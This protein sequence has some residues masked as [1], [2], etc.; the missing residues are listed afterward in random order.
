M[1]GIQETPARLFYDF[2]LEEHV[3]VDHVLRGIDRH[4]A[5]DD[6]R[7]S[8]KPFYSQMG[9]PS[10]DPELM[11]RVLIIGYCM[12]IRSERRL[13]EEIHLNL[14]YRWFCRLGLDGRVPDHST[15]SKNRHG[16]FRESDALRRLFENVV[17]RCIA[18]GLVSAD[19]FA[20]DAS[21]IA[22]D[23]NKQRSVP[24]YAWKPEE[25]GETATR[26][27]QEYLATLDDAAFGA[28]S[29]VTPKFISRSDPAAQWTGA[30]KGHA[31]FAYAN[32]YLIDTD[33]GV[34]VD[35][36]ATRAIRQAEVGA[37]R[38]MLERTETRFGIKPAF[39]A[40]DS[41]YGSAESLAWLVK[42]KE[43][44]PHIP[45]FDK[46]NRTDGTFSR[47]DFVFDVERDRYT[48]PRGQ[49]TGSVPTH[50][51]HSQKRRHS[52]GHKTLSR[53]QIGLRCL[54]TQSPVLPERS[55][56][57]GPAGSGRRCSRHGP[58]A[59][60]NSAIRGGLSAAE[61]NRDAVRP[62]QAN[63]SP[64]ALTPQGP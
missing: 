53:Q 39:L 51:R 26:A 4:L 21:L 16:R 19:G 20:V 28:A 22:A 62:S 34:I 50:I 7:Q 25:I 37:A 31:F 49:R 5:L 29:P 11:I 13:C 57:Q 55:C 36:E 47:A 63:P 18:E 61:E 1:M 60:H 41:A 17:Q 33:H 46:S 6:L 44:A 23:A 24:S 40:A 42:R 45:V 27:A 43:I 59:R 38:T 3:P 9:R 12:G 30:H 14:A 48:C 15:F 2:C 10:V 58:R 54:Q 32:N 64:Y 8:L 35:V 56:P 52:R